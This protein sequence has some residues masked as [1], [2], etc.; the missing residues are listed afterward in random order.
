[1]SDTHKFDGD[2]PELN[3]AMKEARRRLPEFRTALEKDSRRK[4]PV[5]DSPLVKCGFKSPVTGII[6][7]IWIEDVRF[8]AERVVGRLANEP[9]NFPGLTQGRWVSM[10]LD[11]ISDWVYREGDRTIGGFTIRVMEQRGL[12]P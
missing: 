8:E 6:E 11:D 2:D 1:M 10:P 9:D 4:I 5:M 7:H 3:A 12:E